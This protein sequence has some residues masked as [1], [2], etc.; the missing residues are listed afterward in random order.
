MIIRSSKGEYLTTLSVFETF[1]YEWQEI[2][3]VYSARQ[4]LIGSVKCKDI[5]RLLKA[6]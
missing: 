5:A 6:E 1:V 2:L 3:T 4:A